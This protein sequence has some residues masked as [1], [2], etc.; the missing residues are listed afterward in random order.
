[1]HS[2]P[3]QTSAAIGAGMLGLLIGYLA[4]GMWSDRRGRRPVLAAGTALFGLAS[5][6]CAFSAA[7][8]QLIGWRLATGIGIGVAMPAIG[9]LLAEVLPSG[10]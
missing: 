10:R 9:A 7:L 4:G 5:I 8:P 1:F 6:A 2:N 3:A